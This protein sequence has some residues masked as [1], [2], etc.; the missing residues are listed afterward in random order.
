MLIY[1]IDAAINPGNSGGPTFDAA[2]KI[3]GVSSSGMPGKQNVGYIIP[4][5]IAQMFLSEV[6]ETGG[7]SGVSELGVECRRLECDAMRD[8]LSMG[9]ETGV[10]VEAVAPLG[11]LHG[12]I[13]PGDVVTAID[14]H[15]VSNEG[16]VRRCLSAANTM[17][18]SLA[19][20]QRSVGHRFPS[21]PR[22][23]RSTSLVMRS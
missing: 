22:D 7:W 21:R 5:T 23:R 10:L 3:L 9:D 2:G 8:Y 1:Q 4:A 18:S 20:P 17:S 19:C 14:E 13:K 11:A 15:E 16:K 6:Q 12:V